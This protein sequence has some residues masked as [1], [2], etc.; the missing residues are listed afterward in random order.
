MTYWQTQH[1]KA[2][3]RDWY[4]RLAAEGFEDAEE[5]I[6]AEMVLRQ[7]STHPYR[8]SDELRIQSKADYFRCLAQQASEFQFSNDVDRVIMT[9]LAEGAKIKRIREELTSIGESRCR[10]TIRARIRTYEVKWGLRKRA[11]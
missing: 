9:L 8:H 1:F 4:Q 2:T 3:Q 5:L 11:S 6:G 7:S 10:M